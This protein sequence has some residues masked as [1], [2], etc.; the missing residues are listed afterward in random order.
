MMQAHSARYNGLPHVH[1]PPHPSHLKP[2]P[3]SDDGGQQSGDDDNDLDDQNDGVR[4]GK[5]KRPISVS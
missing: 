2:D 1:S 5:R 3:D 4:S